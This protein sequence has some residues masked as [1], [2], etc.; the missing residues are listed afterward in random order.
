MFFPIV[1]FA[2]DYQSPEAAKLAKEL[3]FSIDKTL[4][5]IFELEAKAG[6]NV[7]DIK[8]SIQNESKPTAKFGVVLNK[9]N[10]VIVVT[11]ESEASLL[12]I[13]PNDIVQS[14]LVNGNKVE[15]AKSIELIKGQSI[16]ANL[17]RSDKAMQLKGFVKGTNEVP[18]KLT[19]LVDDKQEVSNNND[20]AVDDD[21]CGRL[22]IFFRPPETKDFYPVMF[23]QVNKNNVI[24]TRE[25]IRVKTG[26]NLVKLNELI[27]ARGLRIKRPN[28]VRGKELTIDVEPNKTYHLAAEFDST[29]RLQSIGETYWKPI[30][31]KVTEKECQL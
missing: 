6:A 7:E 27:A 30:V 19:T 5:R 13:K 11:P 26:E 18:W 14:L 8:I 15:L 22:S 29:K 12:G 25:V 4:S 23:S 1:S 28:M 21:S 24:R 17:L 20:A 2:K 3:K 31:W 16:Q 10:K 9:Q